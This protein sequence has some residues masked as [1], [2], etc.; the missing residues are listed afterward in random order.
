MAYAADFKMG[1]AILTKKKAVLHAQLNVYAVPAHTG[2]GALHTG[3][4]LAY[5]ER[6]NAIREYRMI[7]G[8]LPK[9]YRMKNSSR[10]PDAIANGA[11]TGAS[12]RR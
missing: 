7:P 2:Y 9:T 12:A 4:S 10:L 1:Y 5:P 11:R 8:L 6:S 3:V